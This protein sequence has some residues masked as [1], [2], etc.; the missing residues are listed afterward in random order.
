MTEPVSIEHHDSITVLT[1]DNPPVNALS[2]GVRQGLATGLVAASSD[3]NCRAIVI[4]CVGKTFIA[5]ADI[6]EFARPPEPPFLPDLVEQIA[7][8]A[9]P[10]V[11]ALHGSTLGG[12]FEV[13]M[14]CHYRVA[15]AG[16]KLGLPEVNLGLLPG[17]HGTQL[18]P[19][20]A[21]VPAALDM[22]LS[23]RPIDAADALEK[24][25]VDLIIDER[26]P[27]R[28][29]GRSCTRC[30]RAAATAR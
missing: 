29:G 4:H 21:G 25:I 24:G 1:I 11:A 12:G 22:M 13:A 7:N 20:L 28:G 8:G 30:R 6:R 2:Q 5:G 14:A 19:R 17:A 23:G 3:A 10:V 9:K 27:A 16:T 26:R 18:L 15:A